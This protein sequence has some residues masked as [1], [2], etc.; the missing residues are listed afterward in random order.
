MGQKETDPNIAYEAW[1][2]SFDGT[3]YVDTGVYLY[4]ADNINRDFE[5]LLEK[6][7]GQNGHNDC[8]LNS[9]YENLPY[10]GF[11]VRA[12]G[13]AGCIARSPNQSCEYLRIRRISGNIIVESDVSWSKNAIKSAVFNIPVTLGAGMD[14]Q[15]NPWR[16]SVCTIQH[17][18]I[19]WLS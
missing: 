15:G 1:N 19:K 6:L 17:V 9:M 2:L 12:L 16:Y 13:G 10:P 8:I 5:I 3:N 18:L 14:S 11:V 4:S 7:A